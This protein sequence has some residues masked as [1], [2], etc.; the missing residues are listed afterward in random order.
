V[1]AFKLNSFTVAAGV[2]LFK[3]AVYFETTPVD[4][5]TTS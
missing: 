5:R 2:E 1:L 4:V 3:R